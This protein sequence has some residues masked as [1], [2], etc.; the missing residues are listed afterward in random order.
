MLIDMRVA[1]LTVDPFTNMPI[2]VL[3]C[4]DG[5]HSVA[6]WIG[7]IEASAIATELDRIELDRPMTHDLMATMLERCHV[8]VDRI[9]VHDLRD[10]TFYATVYLKQPDG[11]EVALDARPSDAIALA[12]RAKA[13]IRVA[14]KVVDKARKIDLRTEP[15]LPNLR[16]S[17]VPA[18]GSDPGELELEADLEP[19]TMRGKPGARGSSLR[20]ERLTDAES[21]HAALLESLGET[22]FGKWKM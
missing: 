5:R 12:L 3:K 11:G 13:P 21:T 4:P 2:V 17:A 7:M 6:I 22:A 10:N 14:R 15:P 8:A 18:D 1:S 19:D 20:V 16:A 9:E